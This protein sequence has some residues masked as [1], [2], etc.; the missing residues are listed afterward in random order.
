M[1]RF[2]TALA[3]TIATMT[4]LVLG[5]AALVSLRTLQAAA[6]ESGHAA[7]PLVPGVS[8]AVGAAAAVVVF[9]L[10]ASAVRY[11]V[12]AARALLRASAESR[13]L[14]PIRSGLLVV[15][16]ALPTAFAV[17]GA[18]GHV[19]VSTAMLHALDVDE[20]K[21]FAGT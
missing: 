20:R 12:R 9:V 8:P 10:L 11:F 16:D 13:R 14:G 19:V 17:A 4:G 15:D 18:P 6:R 3:L 2:G 5:V 7:R 1:V 21:V